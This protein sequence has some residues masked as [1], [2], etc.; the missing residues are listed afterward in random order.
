MIRVIGWDLDG[1]LVKAVGLHYR[2]FT[3]AVR[4]I[5]GVEISEEEHDDIYNGLPTRRK[6]QFLIEEGK[7]TQAQAQEIYLLKQSLTEKYAP[8]EIKPDPKKIAMVNHFG[9]RYTMACVSNCIRSSCEMLLRLAGLR[10]QMAVVVSNED[11]DNS[12]PSPDPYYK[13]MSR[14]GV[15]PSECI[16]VEDNRNG[17]LAAKAAGLAVLE[18]EYDELTTQGVRQFILKTEHDDDYY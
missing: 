3:T 12:K 18:T 4:L 17:I 6:L 11:V 9:Q 10:H 16:A 14:L 7:I 15:L 8:E 5:S 2:S 1:V 13:M